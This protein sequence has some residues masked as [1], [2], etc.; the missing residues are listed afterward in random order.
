MGFLYKESGIVPAELSNF[1]FLFRDRRSVPSAD[2]RFLFKRK[3]QRTFGVSKRGVSGWSKLG[4]AALLSRYKPNP[5]QDNKRKISQT[6]NT[7]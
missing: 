6:E 4:E 7:E 5:G 2:L 1:R 3:R